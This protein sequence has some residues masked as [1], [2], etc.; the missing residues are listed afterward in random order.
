MLVKRI[1]RYI[2]SEMVGPFF[3]GLFIF[4]SLWLANLLIRMVNLFVTKGVALQAI[5][6]IFLYSTPAVCITTLPMAMLL[7]TL[8]A[9]GRLSSDSE[10]TAL[11]GCGIGF[12]RLVI[13]MMVAGL[14]ASLGAILFNEKVVPEAN[15]RRE[16]VFINEV[17]LKKPLPKIAKD[18]FFE[19]GDE[20]KMFVRNYSPRDEIMLDVTM[21]QFRRGAYPIVTEAREARIDGEV[22]TFRD[23]RILVLNAQ[24]GGLKE[25]IWFDSWEYPIKSRHADRIERSNKSE[26]EM[27]MAELYAKIQED[28]AKGLPTRKNWVEF[29]FRTSFPFASFFLLLLGAPLAVGNARAGASIGVGLSI[30]IMFVY[31]ICIAVGKAFADGGIVPPFIGAWCPNIVAALLGWFLFHRALSR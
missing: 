3:F 21:Y 2:L 19:G 4:G 15:R 26:K 23:G 27:G 8:L 13:P 1:D 24:D 12:G 18:I 14:V 28:E 20:F 25:E 29:W 31:Y 11:K 16:E 9:L 7:S 10:V 6:E 5:V 30:I 17:V 22:W